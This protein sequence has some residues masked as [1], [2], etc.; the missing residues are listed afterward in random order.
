MYVHLSV[1]VT[2]YSRTW[3]PSDLIRHLYDFYSTVCV[4]ATTH[5]THVNWCIFIYINL[6]MN[7]FFLSISFSYFWK[8]LERSQTTTQTCTLWT[9]SSSDYYL[10]PQAHTV[11]IWE[12]DQDARL[13]GVEISCGWSSCIRLWINHAQGQHRAAD[14]SLDTDCR[15]SCRFLDTP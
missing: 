4:R 11:Y 6:L 15:Q 12:A 10:T 2:E 9:S 7:L 14:R 1:R 3:W 5:Y 13:K 8:V